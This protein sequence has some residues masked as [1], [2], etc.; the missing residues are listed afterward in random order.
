MDNFYKIKEINPYTFEITITIP[1]DSFKK[2]Y[3]L[4]LKDYSKDLDIKGFR[5][6]NVP[7]DLVSDQV[8]EVVQFE[9][10]EKLAPIYINTTISKEK[11]EPIAPPEYK[12]TP[13]ILEGIDIPFTITITTMPDFKLGDIKKV[14][15]KKEDIKVTNEEVQK[16]LDELKESQKTAEKE[17]ND[18]WAKEV[19]KVLGDEKV[20]TLDELKE[21]IKNAIKIQK[22]HYQLHSMQDQA[23]K[24]AIKESKIEIPQA[25]VDFE[26]RERE[27]FFN[28]DIQKKG[29]NIEDFLKANN[30]TIEKMRELWQLDAKEAI[31]TDVFLS[32]Y[33]D[34]KDV[35]ITDKELEERIGAI[36]KERP[37]TDE[38]I[39]SNPQWKEYIKKVERKEKGFRTFI[40]EVLGKEFL[41]SHN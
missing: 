16:A 35:E 36:K 37:D 5:K 30:I 7:S 2:S 3:D 14:K 31:E 41:D 8:K 29:I 23:L 10:F 24:L 20:K 39:F 33:A 4:L 19:G 27:R 40:E 18:K 34:V 21:K 26:A 28:E 15:V 12:E 13:K 1:S 32:L 6:G 22:E 17:L 11:L 25:A 38:S 9:A